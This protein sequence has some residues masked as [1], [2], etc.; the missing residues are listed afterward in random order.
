MGVKDKWK[1][2]SEIFR[3]IL[4]GGSG[5]VIGWFVYNIIYFLN[6]IDAYKATFTWTLAYIFG[7]W[8][9][10]GLHW[11][12]TFERNNLSYFKSLRGSYIAYSM[13]LFISISVN[14]SLVEVFEIHHQLAWLF[15]V[16]SSVA[17]NFVFLKKYA[18][19]DIQP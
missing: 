6:P 4:V 10:H 16:G 12:F 2:Q 14:F 18:F 5:V 9:Q 19:P 1:D 3:F 15:S 13:G 11:N 8:Q 17:V 7:V